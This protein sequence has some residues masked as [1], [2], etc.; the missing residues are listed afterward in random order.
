MTS[1]LELYMFLCFCFFFLLKIP[2]DHAPMKTT[3]WVL[4]NINV[5]G[6]YRV[7]YDQAN[8]ERL[9]KQLNNNHM[10]IRKRHQFNIVC[11]CVNI[12]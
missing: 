6:F 4:A 11:I 9:L 5:A 10:V 12:S 1:C 2:A 8:W 7:N 3:D